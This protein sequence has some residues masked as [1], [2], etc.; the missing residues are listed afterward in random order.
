MQFE[1]PDKNPFQ[2]PENYFENFQLS[3]PKGK[4]K[5][6]FQV[7]DEYFKNLNQ[8]IVAACIEETTKKKGKIIPLHIWRYAIA[9][10]IALVFGF[11]YFGL[12]NT[13]TD[14]VDEQTIAQIESYISTNHTNWHYLE[15]AEALE[16]DNLVEENINFEDQEIIQFLENSFEP[17]EDYDNNKF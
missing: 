8:R 3:L 4:D 16:I 2:I 7:P 10:S 12:Q 13:N 11:S 9:V 14:T 5:Q 6:G 1:K 17:A 15:V